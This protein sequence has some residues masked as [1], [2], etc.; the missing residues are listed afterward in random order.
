MKRIRAWLLHDWWEF[1]SGDLEMEVEVEK[2]CRGYH[3]RDAI[4]SGVTTARV[5]PC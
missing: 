1:T 4:V 5:D 2:M 3:T